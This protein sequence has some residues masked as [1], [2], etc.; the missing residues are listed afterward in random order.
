VR[1]LA[2]IVILAFCI[3]GASAEA[4]IKVLIEKSAR[5]LRVFSGDE[6]K[7]EYKVALGDAPVG[8]KRCQGDERTPEGIY[9]I[10]GRN[11]HSLYYKS[12]RIS[13]P[14]K[15][16]KKISKAMS[17]NPGGDIMIHGLPNGRAW[18]GQNHL[19]DDWT[20]GCIA[21]TNEEMENIWKLVPNGAV[22]EI[23][24]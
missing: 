1:V 3:A 13:Y 20:D 16:D 22:V 4:Q 8:A 9:A 11:P 21:V 5:K 12:L 24:A 15:E 7:L 17:C 23:V 18:I 6:L 14:N 19:M 10:S 2:G